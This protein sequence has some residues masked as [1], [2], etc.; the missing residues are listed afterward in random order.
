MFSLL[1]AEDFLPFVVPFLGGSG[2][3]AGVRVCVCVL[4]YVCVCMLEFLGHVIL[5]LCWHMDN[6]DVCVPA[7]THWP[8]DCKGLTL[9]QV[10]PCIT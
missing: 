5:G 8:C 7:P 6:T 3:L 4:V 1:P 2:P 10:S 9:A